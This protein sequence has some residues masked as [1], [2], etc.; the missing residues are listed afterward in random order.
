MALDATLIA[1]PKVKVYRYSNANNLIKM[2][3]PFQPQ[4]DNLYMYVFIVYDKADY[5]YGFR[6]K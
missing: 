2:I 6:I 4:K 5:H 3:E 1:D